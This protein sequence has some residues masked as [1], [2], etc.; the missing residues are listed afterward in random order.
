MWGMMIHDSLRALDYLTSRADVDASRIATMGI[1]MGSTLAW[2]TAALDERIK[3]C[4]DICCLTDF[5]ALIEEQG[6]GGHGIYYYVP[7]LLKHFTTAEINALTAPRAHLALAGDQDI[8]TPVAGLERI[9]EALR[10]VYADAGAPEAWRLKR[11]DVG[12]CETPDMR[13]EALL[14]LEQ[15]L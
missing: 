11:Y 3:V 2:W 14:F 1:S 10:K 8:L 12:H 13:R 7:G 4:I 15:R 9:D 5:Q 6:L